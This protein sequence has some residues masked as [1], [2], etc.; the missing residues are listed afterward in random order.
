MVSIIILQG[1]QLI[2]NECAE[3]GTILEFV[4]IVNFKSFGEVDQYSQEQERKFVK[5]VEC[6][7]DCIQV[8]SII[9]L[10]EHAGIALTDN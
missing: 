10:V 8:N 5:V 7:N 4:T 3:I 9:I 6:S 2:T 1:S